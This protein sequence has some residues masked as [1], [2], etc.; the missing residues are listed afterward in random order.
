MNKKIVMVIM[1][2]VIGFSVLGIGFGKQ[3]AEAKT[4]T[5]VE[6]NKEVKGN[7]YAKKMSG[8]FV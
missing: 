5:T 3:H 1:S 2:T 6:H 7:L 4:K 8:R